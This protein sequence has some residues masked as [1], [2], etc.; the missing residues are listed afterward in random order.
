VGSGCVRTVSSLALLNEGPLHAQPAQPAWRRWTA[1]MAAL[2]S[3]PLPAISSVLTALDADEADLQLGPGGAQGLDRAG[4]ESDGGEELEV[5]Q[6]PD[7]GRTKAWYWKF[8][9]S[10]LGE[11]ARTGRRR[12]RT[13]AHRRLGRVLP[14]ATRL[15]RH[16]ARRA[17][18]QLERIH[19]AGLGRVC[20]QREPRPFS[21]LAEHRRYASSPA[22]PGQ[23][24][25]RITYTR[26][27]TT[28]TPSPRRP[29]TGP[30]RGAPPSASTAST[31]S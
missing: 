19:A 26:V 2:S 31:G 22:P 21:P 10:P 6:Q 18:D 16:Q 13:S 24:G 8:S 4:Y 28:T 11:C 29:G 20:R 5:T 25:V 17:H 23:P 15:R 12:H 3:L 27:N 9:K 7:A 14:H 1:L 30:A